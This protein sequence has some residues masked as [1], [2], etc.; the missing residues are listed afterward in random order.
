MVLSASDGGITVE[1]ILL[2]FG[3]T[4]VGVSLRSLRKLWVVF[5]SPVKQ[6]LFC[7]RRVRG[8][9]KLGLPQRCGVVDVLPLVYLVEPLND[10]LI[11]GGKPQLAIGFI[12]YTPTVVR[13]RFDKIGIVIQDL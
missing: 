6:I 9:V 5:F 4:V 10:M 13:R 7:P 1:S 11:L 3:A 2:A 12:G 8:H